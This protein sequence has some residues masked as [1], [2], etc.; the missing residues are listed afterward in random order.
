MPKQKQA[1]RKVSTALLAILMLTQT[2]ILP[3]I[4]AQEQQLFPILPTQAYHKIYTATYWNYDKKTSILAYKLVA[5]TRF[6]NRFLIINITTILDA[7]NTAPLTLNIT[8]KEQLATY[9]QHVDKVKQAFESNENK[10]WFDKLLDYLGKNKNEAKKTWDQIIDDAKQHPARTYDAIVYYTY[11]DRPDTTQ[12]PKIYVQVLNHYDGIQNFKTYLANMIRDYALSKTLGTRIHWIYDITSAQVLAYTNLKYTNLRYILDV[13]SYPKDFWNVTKYQLSLDPTFMLLF[14]ADMELKQTRYS[15]TLTPETLPLLQAK[16][17]PLGT[18]PLVFDAFDTIQN[19]PIKKDKDILSLL[20]IFSSLGF[21]VPS[22]GAVTSLTA[23]K[24][25]ILFKR[26]GY[27]PLQ[28]TPVSNLPHQP[29][30]LEQF[31][32]FVDKLFH[33]TAVPDNPLHRIQQVYVDGTPYIIETLAIPLTD[34][35]MLIPQNPPNFVTLTAEMYPETSRYNLTEKYG[36]YEFRPNAVAYDNYGTKLLSNH[37]LYVA[38]MMAFTG[39]LIQLADVAMLMMSFTMGN[40]NQ[41]LTELGSLDFISK[42][43]LGKEV[44]M[45]DY[46]EVE[47]VISKLPQQGGSRSIYDL[48]ND[49]YI[50]QGKNP[51]GVFIPINEAL[52]NGYDYYLDKPEVYD[53]LQK[54]YRDAIWQRIELSADELTSFATREYGARYYFAQARENL[55]RTYRELLASEKL[56]QADK[57]HIMKKL[58]FIEKLDIDD[59]INRAVNYIKRAPSREFDAQYVMVEEGKITL[60]PTEVKNT[61]TIAK[62]PDTLYAELVKDA[63]IEGELALKNPNAPKTVIWLID[64]TLK[65]HPTEAV[66]DATQTEA[67][68]DFVSSYWNV[69]TNTHKITGSE[70]YMILQEKLLARGI[71][72]VYVTSETAVQTTLRQK[73]WDIIKKTGKGLATKGTLAAILFTILTDFTITTSAG[74]L[75]YETLI[76]YNY[77]I[78]DL[79]LLLGSEAYGQSVKGTVVTTAMSNDTI[80][81]TAVP[82]GTVTKIPRYAEYLYMAPD[83]KKYAYAVLAEK[84]PKQY[85]GTIAVTIPFGITPD[86]HQLIY[87][88]YIFVDTGVRA[89]DGRAVVMLYDIRFSH[90]NLTYPLDIF[91]LN[92][93]TPTTGNQTAP[94]FKITYKN[95]DHVNPFNPAWT[96]KDNWTYVD[97]ASDKTGLDT[98]AVYLDVYEIR[99]EPYYQ[100]AT[101]YKAY[102]SNGTIVL[103]TNTTTTY[104]NFPYIERVSVEYEPINR[105]AFAVS[106]SIHNFTIPPNW[107]YELAWI[108]FYENGYGFEVV[109]VIN[110][111][112]S[113]DIVFLGYYDTVNYFDVPLIYLSKQ[114][115][116][117]RWFVW[118]FDIYPNG[119]AILSLYDEHG[120]LIATSRIGTFQMYDPSYWWYDFY[121]WADN[122]TNTVNVNGSTFTGTVNIDAK[123]DWIALHHYD[124]KSLL[125]PGLEWV[126]DWMNEMFGYA[127][128]I[129]NRTRT[130][131]LYYRGNLVK[132]FNLTYNPICTYMYNYVC[133]SYVYDDYYED[134]NT[135]SYAVDYMILRDTNGNI[136]KIIDGIYLQKLPSLTLYY[137]FKIN[138][139]LDI[140]AGDTTQATANTISAQSVSGTAH[141]TSTTTT[142]Q[143]KHP[144]ITPKSKTPLEPRIKPAR[145]KS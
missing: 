17:A 117:N 134:G 99:V 90:K 105:F 53:L 124:N 115:L 79:Q 66:L 106:W 125:A 140:M 78:P 33:K 54:Y 27:N 11:P 98:T 77:G 49:F 130:L 92:L 85:N 81:I 22:T 24:T 72:R 131:E 2:F 8:S 36:L 56:S 19:P 95:Y 108:A 38:G 82:S 101:G 80:N 91:K 107:H 112:S 141:T 67:T 65:G 129:P 60:V 15:I 7:S 13:Q 29:T 42:M 144:Q 6:S 14:L 86:L 35:T 73:L 136:T 69:V 113:P 57:E 135:E 145:G 52:K 102:V 25:S 103:T 89:E 12:T 75:S 100:R 114:E 142:K 44:F 71:T 88:T 68:I 83:N 62:Y 32:K 37:D 5:P 96:P 48:I 132:K 50:A 28:G 87:L 45:P 41:V 64:T 121:I 47:S 18:F 31:T 39:K 127:G 118:N 104:T 1:L 46:K 119:T 34:F 40:T 59:I 120:N 3:P 143:P 126:A 43:F 137:V 110:Q 26:T 51:D 116:S 133:K 97:S 84:L 74:I 10:W 76:Q 123:I 94:G 9:Q 30:I 70:E 63:Y 4:S 93:T 139:A 61:W 138:P 58:N 111:T 122:F 20:D 128:G 21:S 23:V 55:I 16:V 109:P